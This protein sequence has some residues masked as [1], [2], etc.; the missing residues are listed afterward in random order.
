M[1]GICLISGGCTYNREECAYSHLRPKKGGAL[2]I[3]GARIT[4]RLQYSTHMTGAGSALTEVNRKHNTTSCS[5]ASRCTC[6]NMGGL[7]SHDK[8]GA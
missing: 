1:E 8:N 6:I 2:I 7:I 5:R 3:E 4:A